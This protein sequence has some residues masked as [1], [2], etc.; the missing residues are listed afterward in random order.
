MPGTKCWALPD[1][2]KVRSM[3]Y[4]SAL[5][6]STPGLDRCA[7]TCS[8]GLCEW[9]HLSVPLSNCSLAV[10]Y[11]GM[12][13]S[14]LAQSPASLTGRATNGLRS[15]LST[16]FTIRLVARPGTAT[17]AYGGRSAGSGTKLPSTWS[18]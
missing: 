4:T 6:S 11:S 16:C 13:T 8:S 7:V 1:S 12:R 15:E 18:S 10:L 17:N 9:M 5:S 14:T 3:R 2:K